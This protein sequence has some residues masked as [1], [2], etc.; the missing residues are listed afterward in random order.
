MLLQSTQ[1]YFGSL[2]DEQ[3]VATAQNGNG[4]SK[5][6]AEHLLQKHRGLVLTK[7]YFLPNAEPEDLYQERRSALWE[8]ITSYNP[9]NGTPLERF[10]KVCI[11][12][13]SR[14]AVRLATT[15]SAR[16]VYKAHQLKE[17][18]VEGKSLTPEEIVVR[19]D[20]QETLSEKIKELLLS[21]P[22]FQREVMQQYMEGNSPSA[23]AE[24]LGC[25]PKQVDNALYKAKRNL[26]KHEEEI[27]FILS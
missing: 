22:N 23:I 21:L 2:T 4:M 24:S 7:S 17:E 8:A 11:G 16:L 14:T 26:R 19:R 25:N 20:M 27:S 18:V 1:K 10:A 15:P 12:K 3:L 9:S 13:R 6:A 5:P